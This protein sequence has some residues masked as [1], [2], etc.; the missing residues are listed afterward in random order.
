MNRSLHRLE[1]QVARALSEIIHEMKDP[2]LPLVVTVE[3]VC[4][5]PDLSQGRVL[6]SALERVEET[7]GILNRAHGFL[8]E[9]LARELRLRRIPRLRFF[10]DPGEVL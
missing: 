6:V 9:E 10:A 2:R 8:Q 7:V 1:V 5:T 3:R 4:L